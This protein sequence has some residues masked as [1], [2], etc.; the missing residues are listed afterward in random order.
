MSKVLA[1]MGGRGT[2]IFGAPLAD[3]GV[4]VYNQHK[5]NIAIPCMDLLVRPHVMSCIWTVFER[6][7]GRL[8]STQAV[9]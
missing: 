9:K 7:Y 1:D 2:D 6:R 3:C 8:H 5:V 4:S